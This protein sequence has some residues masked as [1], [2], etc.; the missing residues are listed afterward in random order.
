MM[1][2]LPELKNILEAA[3]KAASDALQAFPR[4]PMGLT[5]DRVKASPE[6]QAAQRAYQKA[7]RD[8]RN[9]NVD[10]AAEIRAIRR[11]EPRR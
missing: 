3:H 7:H 4:G 6:W 10:H 11:A 9:F 8:L 2:G 1:R 5:P